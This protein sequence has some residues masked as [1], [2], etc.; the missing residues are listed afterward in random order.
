MNPKTANKLFMFLL[1]IVFCFSLTACGAG[2]EENDAYMDLSDYF[3]ISELKG[4]ENLAVVIDNSTVGYGIVK[5]D[6][7]VY[8]PYSV[9]RSYVNNKFYVDYKEQLLIYTTPDYSVDSNIGQ[10]TYVDNGSSKTFEKQISILEGENVYISMDYILQMQNNINFEIFKDPNVLVIRTTLNNTMTAVTD[11]GKVRYEADPMSEILFDVK[12][13]DELYVVEST[14]KGTYTKVANKAGVVGYIKTELIGEKKEVMEELNYN[15][16][17]YS[18]IKRDYKICLGWHQMETVGGND[19]LYEVMSNSTDLNVIS[20]TWY[21]IS[22][23]EGNFTSCSSIDYV[24][25]AHQENIEVWALISD[26]NYDDDNQTYFINLALSKTSTRRALISN[27]IDEANNLNLD[28]I[29]IDFEHIGLDYAYDYVEFIRE[30]SIK[31]RKNNIILSVDMYVPIESNK[32]YD[33]TSVGEAA[34][35]VIVM[36]YDEHWAGC[37]SAGSTASIGFVSDGIANTISEVDPS[38]VINAIPFYTRVWS[39]TPEDMAE[40]DD[41]IIEDNIFGNYALDSYAV[42]LNSAKKHLSDNGANIVWL[43]DIGQHYGEY[44]VD[45]ITYRIWLEDYDSLALK[46]S[47]ME[48]YKLGGVACWKLGLDNSEAWD[49]IH[50]YMN[51]TN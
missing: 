5:D 50:E 3:G 6:G 43:E 17:V 18:H 2:E 14:D 9:I 42:G 26:F 23:G 25:R 49:A 31:C 16:V 10:N 20:P 8:M 19:G 24:N 47:K 40:E 21:Q 41:E 30:L 1:C 33:R 15:P 22:D 28:G 36:G 13:S 46:L 4:S 12:E 34:D 48:E 45:G 11:D 7:S 51:K 35:Y 39:E 32:Y 44:K 29:N 38:R 27:L 37:N